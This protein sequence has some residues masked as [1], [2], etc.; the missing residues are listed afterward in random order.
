MKS[1]IVNDWTWTVYA[2]ILC[3][4][5]V[6]TAHATPG[7]PEPDAVLYGTATINGVSV[8]QQQVVAVIAL[9]DAGQEVG[10]FNFNDCN[11]NG[12]ADSCELSCDAPGCA[13]V[14]GCGT[15][16]DVEPQDGLLDDCP[17]NLYVLRI[18]SESV[19][20]GLSPSGQAVVLNA[21]EPPVVE[22]YLKDG[23][24]LEQLAREFAISERGKIRNIGLLPADLTALQGLL[25]CLTGP[26]GTDP[27][28][29][30]DAVQ[31][32][33]FDYNEDHRVDL[34]DYYYLQDAFRSTRSH[35]R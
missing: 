33:T 21:S 11:A 1:I 19:P 6:S 29:T 20:E 22:V 24:G 28:K 12:V 32:A 4:A 35:T 15:A 17:G 14:D 31:R 30:C 5:L 9:T 18:R 34:R 26:D 8:Q 13:G 23:D 3:G 16:R 25:D 2:V 10:R 27:S 7:I